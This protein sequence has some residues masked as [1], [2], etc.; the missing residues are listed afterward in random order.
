[1]AISRPH[2]A[3]RLMSAIP[4]IADIG[5]LALSTY[6]LPP[7]IAEQIRQN[8]CH[9]SDIF[10]NSS[11]DGSLIISADTFRCKRRHG[12]AFMDLKSRDDNL[13]DPLPQFH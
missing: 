3:Y 10:L 4:P 7:R 8:H 6:E 5:A 9:S 12:G 1:M 13:A 2:A 11:D